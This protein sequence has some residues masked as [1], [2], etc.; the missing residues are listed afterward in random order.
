MQENVCSK[1]EIS[2]EENGEVK[3]TNGY[4]YYRTHSR[5]E[6]L[7]AVT[8]HLMQTLQAYRECYIDD[9]PDYKDRD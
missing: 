7:T 9:I 5:E 1:W 2:E 4:E 8:T 3:A 6:A